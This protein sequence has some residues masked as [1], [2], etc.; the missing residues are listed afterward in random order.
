MLSSEINNLD[1]DELKEKL[2]DKS[3]VAFLQY[4]HITTEDGIPLDWR[5]HE[6]MIDVYEDMF[7]LKRNIVGLKAAQ[8]TFTTTACNAVLCIAKKKKINIIYTLPTFD[9]IRVFSGGKVN[10][11][12]AQNPI[13]QS[14]VPNKDTME[15]KAVDSNVIHFRG[16][17]SPKAATMIPSD[18]NVYDEVDSSNQEVVEQYAT[19]LQH[20]QLKREWW[21]SHPSVPGNGVDKH[22]PKSDQ[23]HW[24]IKCPACKKEH[25]MRWP[26][27]IDRERG[28]YQ[29]IHCR[30]E[31]K[32][33][34]RRHGRWIAKFKNREYSGYWI[35]LFICPWVPATEIINYHENKS[36]E[37]FYNKVLGLPYVGGGNKVLQTQIYSNLTQELHKQEDRIVIGLDTGVDLRYVVGNRQQGLFFYGECKNYEEIERMLKRWP[38]SILVAD[39]GGDIIG[40]RELR[41]KYPGRVFLAAYSAADKKTLQLVRWGKNDEDGAVL[42]DRNRM[43]QLVIDE[44]SDRRLP[45]HFVESVD[46][47]YDYWL[48]WNHIYRV[49]VEDKGTKKMVYRWE[50]SDRDDWVHATV[51][52]RTGIGR[53]GGKGAIVAADTSSQPV[54]QSYYITPDNKTGVNPLRPVIDKALEYT[55]PDEDEDGEWRA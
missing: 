29:C 15:Q 44:F 31:L 42:I 38:R 19:R 20:S 13:Y 12:I 3:I 32:N 22:W 18:L 9:D 14:W 45:L 4:H 23:K 11:I 40:I 27:S 46:D 2:L 8:I 26:E 10:R 6:F 17:H 47:W 49:S 55:P 1:K 24:F 33:N 5:N 30:A 25:Y 50:R 43:I 52:W 51:Y 37:Y 34:D 54:P 35:P 28:I 36:P 21:F 16:T 7:S 48:H 39:Q 41:E 53:F